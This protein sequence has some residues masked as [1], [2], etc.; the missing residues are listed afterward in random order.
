MLLRALIALALLLFSH[1]AA[2][3]TLTFAQPTAT[4]FLA[5]ATFEVRSYVQMMSG[6]TMQSHELLR[7]GTVIASGIT[8][9]HSRTMSSLAVGSYRFTIRV[10][11]NYGNFTVDKVVNVLSP[12]GA[13]PTVQLGAI[14]GYTVAPATL[15]LSAT[16]GDTDGTIAR[17]EFFAN[18][19]LIATDW[20]APYA[21]SWT[22]V[23]AGTYSVF[24][25]AYDDRGNA[26]D[27]VAS[28]VTV[29][30]STITGHIDAVRLVDGVYHLAGWACSTGRNESVDV[31]VYV[32]GA[33]GTG[34]GILG[35][36]ADAASEPA[37]AHACQ[38]YGTA[39]RFSIPL[40]A[41][42]RAQHG[43]KKIYVHGI[44]PIGAANLL[45][46]GSG[47][48]TV[49]P[50]LTAT[51]RYVYDDRQRLCKVIEPE[52]G[53][54][55]MGYDA[56]GNLQ[57]SASGLALPS[58]TECNR[59]EA[60]ASGRV[61]SRTYDARNRI[62]GLYFPDGRGNQTWTYTKDG[63]PET[64]TTYNT[65]GDGEPV[66][67]AYSYNRRRLLVGESVSQPGWYTWS[68]GYHLNANG[69]IDR[70][71]TP[72]G[73]VL[74]YQPNALGQVR[75][76][77]SNGGDTFASGI[78]YH[79]NGAIRHFTYGNGVVHTMAQNARQLPSRVTSSG[80]T[81]HSYTYDANGNI[82]TIGDHVRGG[83][84]GRT[85][86]YDELDRLTYAAS[87]SFGGDCKHRFTYDALD[88]MRSWKLA[89]VK[90]Y[91]EYYYNPG[92]NRL[93]AIRNS[94]G[95]QLVALEYDVQG[96]LSQKN[97]HSYAFDFGNRLRTVHASGQYQEGY[98]YDG[99]GR[100]VLAW[101]P[102]V[103]SILSMYAQSGQLIYEEDQR[104]NKSSSHIYLGGSVI[105]KRTYDLTAA[106]FTVS[107]QHTDALGSP[108]AVTDQAGTVI[109]RTDFEPYG[110]A[111]GKPAYQGIGYTGHVMDGATGLTY[112]QQRYYDQSI[113]RF[114]SVD[115][116]AVRPSAD[117]FNRYSYAL[118]NPFRFTDPDGRDP[119][120][121]NRNS[122]CG[123]AP[124]RCRAVVPVP[125]ATEKGFIE[126]TVAELRRL[127]EAI[128]SPSPKDF[129]DASA[130]ICGAA[131]GAAGC[132]RVG[133]ENGHPAADLNVGAGWARGFKLELVSD[134]PASSGQS[135]SRAWLGGDF[136]IGVSVAGFSP[137]YRAGGLLVVRPGP[138]KS[139]HEYEG[140]T[141]PRFKVTSAISANAR[142][143]AGF[144]VGVVGQTQWIESED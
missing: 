23:A 113:G 81:D 38:A 39:Y 88:N 84:H 106:K 116:V 73:M 139:W 137:G 16:A 104:T 109:D 124:A 6:E 90:D 142:A 40:T 56:A 93:D 69:H 111:I 9:S 11:T 67:N 68:Q 59:D 43:G 85:L 76:I 138:S 131:R 7:D 70:V 143:I 45:I 34:T 107:Y 3:A 19:G 130:K 44:S 31:H 22:N 26:T 123:H 117:N 14:T 49:P 87:C 122:E 27:S 82:K 33:A 75:S 121:R 132:I 97:A 114:L 135:D 120:P 72:T 53:A 64:I 95:A 83:H 8:T 36:R 25:R 15:G 41:A 54:T 80:T 5:P 128:G 129:R 96:N 28:S 18:G 133:F 30:Q 55:V 62:D 101:K 48:F 134:W 100:R 125:R 71:H 91:A 37:V 105:A 21:H 126:K 99:H 102:G 35:Y 2:A 13:F 115:P 60:A 112:M 89:G 57:W 12:T 65:G 4:E 52:T 61:V 108:V 17:V 144:R 77:T 42:I 140:P 98:R 141:S 24:A 20:S 118:N 94:G 63:L 119:L 47:H 103:G 29:T 66:A 110:A 74:N 86:D 127:A 78:A 136:D 92:N 10:R 79:P 50:T 46:G 51:R 1:A 58:T 32:G